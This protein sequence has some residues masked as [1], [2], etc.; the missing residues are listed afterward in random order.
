MKLIQKIRIEYKIH[1]F[2]GKLCD[3]FSEEEV[4]SA[5]ARYGR[6]YNILPTD[7]LKE[8]YLDVLLKVLKN[9]C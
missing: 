8:R 1:K 9:E 6:V 5:A 7:S 2:L 3:I 4:Y